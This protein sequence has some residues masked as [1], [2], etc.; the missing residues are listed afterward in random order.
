MESKPSSNSPGVPPVTPLPCSGRLAGIDFGTVRI[1]IAISDPSQTWA[2]PLETYQVRG[3]ELDATFFRSL[4]ER[5][6]LVGWVVGLPLHTSGQPS[7]KSNQAVKFG[8]WIAE[9]T[10]LPVN[11]ID[12]RFTTAAAREMLSAATMSGKKKKAS[13]DKIA[14]QVIL[15]TYLESDRTKVQTDHSLE[16]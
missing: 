15:S 9:A 11:W 7:K 12:E 2:S 10:A 1:G 5:E 6:A 13:L 4:V 3:P 8:Q 14:A 16:D